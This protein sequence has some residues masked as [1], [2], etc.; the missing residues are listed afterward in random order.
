MWSLN[1]KQNITRP[2]G[3]EEAHV[4]IN[5]AKYIGVMHHNV[6]FGEDDRQPG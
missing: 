6:H 3:I 1:N 2:G 5:M 4:I